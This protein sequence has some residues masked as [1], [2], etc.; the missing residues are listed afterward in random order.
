MKL[1]NF[2]EQIRTIMISYIFSTC[3]ANNTRYYKKK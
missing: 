2:G 1:P 3:Y